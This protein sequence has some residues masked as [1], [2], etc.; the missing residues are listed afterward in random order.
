MTLCLSGLHKLFL[1]IVVNKVMGLMMKLGET[2][3]NF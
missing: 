3:V 2:E 1:M